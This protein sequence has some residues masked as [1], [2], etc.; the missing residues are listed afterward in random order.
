M[1]PDGAGCE[2]GGNLRGA[3]PGRVAIPSW[4]LVQT[5]RNL[6]FAARFVSAT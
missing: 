3:A 4:L 6:G 1:I 5:L 2:P